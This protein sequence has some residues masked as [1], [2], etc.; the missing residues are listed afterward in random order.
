[1]QSRH[2]RLKNESEEQREVRLEHSG[3]QL[4]AESPEQRQARLQTNI[5]VITSVK[6]WLRRHLKRDKP[7]CRERR[8]D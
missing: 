2:D 1:M 4:A 5:I 6:D 3:D 7:G 8:T